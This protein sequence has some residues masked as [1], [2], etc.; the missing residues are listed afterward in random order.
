MSG[1]SE[2]RGRPGTSAMA[3]PP[4]TRTIGYGT[5]S[6]RATS[7]SAATAT[8]SPTTTAMPDTSPASAGG[9]H[10]TLAPVL[11]APG[12]VADQRHGRV[13]VAEGPGAAALDGRP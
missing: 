1:C 13:A 10:P 4:S 5:S 8:M 7:A 6:L 11:D 2:T 3:R 12:G 9:G